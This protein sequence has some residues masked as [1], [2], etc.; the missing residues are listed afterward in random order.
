MLL[1]LFCSQRNWDSKKLIN[2]PNNLFNYKNQC[3]RAGIKECPCDEH[4]VTY[5]IVEAPYCTYETN[6][7]LYVNYIGILKA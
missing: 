5:R 6:I 1:V 2:L 7:A 4:R 3:Y